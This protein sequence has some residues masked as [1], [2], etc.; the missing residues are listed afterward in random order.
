MD[1]Q[2]MREK[3]IS[4]IV[5]M[6][7]QKIGRAR[8]NYIH[9][10]T[11]EYYSPFE[12]LYQAD[13]KSFAYVVCGL[14]DLS[15]MSCSNMDVDSHV[16]VYNISMHALRLSAYFQIKTIEIPM[17]LKKLFVYSFELQK[18]TDVFE[19][20]NGLWLYLACA[21]FLEGVSEKTSPNKKQLYYHTII[22]HS[23][24]FA[25]FVALSEVKDISSALLYDL[26]AR[27]GY[28][29]SNLKYIKQALKAAALYD[30]LVSVEGWQLYFYKQSPTKIQNDI[31]VLK[32]VGYEEIPRLMNEIVTILEFHEFNS[33]KEK[34][35]FYNRAI[36][37]FSN[38]IETCLV[39]ENLKIVDRFLCNHIAKGNRV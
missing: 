17:L 28:V 26:C 32:E 21:D 4:T 27:L 14:R 6:E 33:K 3:L 2:S 12:Q 1:F 22:P 29:S 39:N 19:C 37:K 24:V 25:D 15:D 9:I 31:L 11:P 34:M 20:R 8:C 5:Y 10:N 7:K 18:S 16:A 38:Q 13:T 36:N 35:H 30:N 23:L